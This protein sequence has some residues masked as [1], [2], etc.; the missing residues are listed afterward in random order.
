MH[1]KMTT[2]KILITRDEYI[3]LKKIEETNSELRKEIQQLKEDI[4]KVESKG[5][6][7]I[8][9]KVASLENLPS[10]STVSEDEQSESDLDGGGEEYDPQEANFLRERNENLVEINK[11]PLAAPNQTEQTEITIP[12]TKKSRTSATEGE[13]ESSYL[14]LLYPKNRKKGHLFL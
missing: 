11:P 10:A 8:N 9:P 5:S 1:T 3:R 4:R 7:D 6:K 2:V 14:E 13:A 12:L